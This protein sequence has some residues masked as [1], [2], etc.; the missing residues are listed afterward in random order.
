MKSNWSLFNPYS[1]G[2]FRSLVVVS[3]YLCPNIGNA[4]SQSS[5]IIAKGTTFYIYRMKG[6]SKI[7]I[8]IRY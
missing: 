6:G 4:V 7:I 1:I 5:F 3:F 2:M 8:S